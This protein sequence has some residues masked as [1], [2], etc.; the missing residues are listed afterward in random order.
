[1]DYSLE[2]K[3]LFIS[4]MNDSL[5]FPGN[6]GSVKVISLESY[7]VIK[8]IYSGFQPNGISVNHR[9]GYLAIVNSNISPKGPKPHH[10]SGCAGRNGNI[11]FV[12]LNTLQLIPNKR[13]ELAV[14]PSAISLKE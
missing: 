11:T 14:F 7:Q 1:M 13:T 8:T 10:T 3:M 6:L 12:D 5:S 2:K 9:Y 4:C